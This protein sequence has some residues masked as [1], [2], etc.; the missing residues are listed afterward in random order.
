MEHVLEFRLPNER[1]ESFLG[2]KGQ[3]WLVGGLVLAMLGVFGY[4]LNTLIPQWSLEHLVQVWDKVRSKPLDM[5]MLPLLI[6]PLFLIPTFLIKLQRLLLNAQGLTWEC[7]LPF[8]WGSLPGMRWHFAWSQIAEVSL[9][10]ARAQPEHEWDLVSAVRIVFRLHDGTQRVL[11]PV[12]WFV[13]G[14]PKRPRSKLKYRPFSYGLWEDSENMTLLQETFQALPLV[15]VLGVH[16]VKLPELNPNAL[17][18]Q[19]QDVLAHPLAKVLFAAALL[20]FV[21]GFL[22]MLGLPHIH[23]HTSLDWADRL[24]LGVAG[25]VIALLGIQIWNKRLEG[26]VTQAGAVGERPASVSSKSSLYMGVVLSLLAWFAAV[27]VVSEPVIS[28]IATMGRGGT[29]LTLRYRFSGK[30]LQPLQTAMQ[31]PPIDL[32]GTESRIA[33]IKAGTEVEL[34]S[35]PGRFGIW[36]YD[37]TPLRRL[38][39]AQG[40][41]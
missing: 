2:V 14:S 6:W 10:R 32:P 16:G 33:R 15:Q 20:L 30:H 31:V 19:Q 39:D 28:Q 36:V 17:R 7:P 27:L 22:L 29:E 3:K 9:D 25:V 34:T 8:G 21:V 26:R 1:Y 11:M 12:S 41:Q 23:P 4:T 38:A 40:V 18:I 5:S 24:T 35:T 13:P 37:D